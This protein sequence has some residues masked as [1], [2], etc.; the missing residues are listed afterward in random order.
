MPAES[1]ERLARSPMSGKMCSSNNVVQA[2]RAVEQLRAEAGM[3][4]VKISI[5]AAQLVQ[6][7]E[8]HGRSDPL[9]TGIAA[10]ANPFKDKKSCVLL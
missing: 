2:R 8:E 7:C 4:R 1:V 10:S 3:E 9:L 6:Y 5:A